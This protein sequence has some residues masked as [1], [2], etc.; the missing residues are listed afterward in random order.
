MPT[1]E[2]LLRTHYSALGRGDPDAAADVFA[3]GVPS[4]PPPLPNDVR[5]RAR[6]FVPASDERVVVLGDYRAG[7]EAVP[8]VHTWRFA[9][10][11]VVEVTDVHD[12]ARLGALIAGAGDDGGLR[13]MATGFMVSQVLHAA[14]DVGVFTALR[15][16]P[17]DGESLRRRLGLHERGARDFFDALAALGLLE[18]GDGVYANTPVTAAHLG[19][20]EADSYLG[21]L[22]AYI[23]SHWYWSWGRLADALRTGKSQSYGGE[24]PY[25][26]IQADPELAERFQQAMFATSTAL[27]AAIAG[28][29]AWERVGTVA[30]IGCADGSLLARLL[31]AHPHL[32]GIGFDL[33]AG[34]SGFRRTVARHGLEDRARFEA[35]DF[36]AGPLPRAD[37]L[38]FAHILIDW[39]AETRHMLLAKAYRAL[40]EGGT[41][42]IVDTLLEETR[43]P[44]SAAGLLVGLHMLVDQRGGPSYSAEECF[45]WLG[46]AGFRDRRVRSL[47]GFDRL[48]TAVK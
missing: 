35:G 31:T 24:F 42:L 21:G 9:D 41:I 45:D 3:D 10:G 15:D 40:P 26:A 32:R 7:D 11:K 4:A 8:F 30:D 18:R 36:R 34:V 23:G 27:R 47:S 38:L 12:A 1:N 2:E 16:G 20:A 19:D 25:D 33:P 46:K 39:D 17:M 43:G 5:P 44:D 37:A 29:F 28:G 22:L 13:D 6:E 14:V 48:I